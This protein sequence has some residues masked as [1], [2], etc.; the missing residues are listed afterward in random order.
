MYIFH[1]V[2]FGVK[3][4]FTT[5]LL[6]AAEHYATQREYIP[7]PPPHLDSEWSKR[8]RAAVFDLF[9]SS[10]LFKLK[11]KKLN[12]HWAEQSLCTLAEARTVYSR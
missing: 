6:P 8:L 10:L 12:K 2:M 3:Y 5:V 9:F 4:S 1:K 11:I 7:T